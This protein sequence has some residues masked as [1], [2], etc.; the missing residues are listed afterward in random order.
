[1][2]KKINSAFNLTHFVVLSL[3][4][5]ARRSLYGPELVA[6]AKTVRDFDEVG[7]GRRR[8]CKLTVF[9]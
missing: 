3:G 8:R 2:L 1:M 4:S 6:A 9:V 5:S 7:G